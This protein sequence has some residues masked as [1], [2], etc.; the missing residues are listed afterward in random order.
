MARLCLITA[1][2]ARELVAKKELG[3]HAVSAVVAERQSNGRGTR[4]RKW[5]HGDRNLFMTVII[6]KKHI[7]VPLH[8]LP[9]RSGTLVANALS[10]HIS[11]EE[12][13]KL[14]WPND[15]LVDGRK[16]CGILIEMEGDHLLVGIGCNIATAPGVPSSGSEGGRPSTSLAAHS[17]PLQQ[18]LDNEEEGSAEQLR[19]YCQRITLDVFQQFVGWV[20]AQ[21]DSAQ[22]VLADFTKHMDFST[23]R[24]RNDHVAVAVDGD[25]AMDEAMALVQPLGLNADGTLRVKQMHSGQEM[26]LVAEYLR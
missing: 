7:P 11:G 4:G 22:A 12:S 2:Q 17:P 20:D 23:Q 18:L 9:L 14:K 26:T 6:D 19:Q 3:G 8:Y 16:L 15:I 10:A 1:E 13:M 5:L 25:S 24:L 21:A